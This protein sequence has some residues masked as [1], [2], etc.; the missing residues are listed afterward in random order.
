MQTYADKAQAAEEEVKDGKKYQ[1]RL[2]GLREDYVRS[3]GSSDLGCIA[4]PLLSE[5][6]SKGI[7]TMD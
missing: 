6:I 3:V 7:N 2:H 4:A 1:K 5:K